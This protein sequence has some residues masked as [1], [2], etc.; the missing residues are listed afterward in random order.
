[1]V[2]ELIASLAS[3]RFDEN[4]RQW[5]ERL[6]RE[7]ADLRTLLPVLH[8]GGKVPMYF[9][10]VLGCVV[11]KAPEMMAPAL[12]ALF[13]LR[14]SLQ[15][16]GYRRSLAKWMYHAGL[17]QGM[18]G[19]AVDALFRWARDPAAQVSTRRFA[20][21]GLCRLVSAGP[22]SEAYGLREELRLV[23]EEQGELHTSNF[24]K[25]ASAMLA[26]LSPE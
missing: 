16:Q 10:W 8:A 11:E 17:P 6:I 23:L 20:L 21:L 18:E 2:E 3:D 25:Q 9:T 12:P 7:R 5:C 19:E 1:M 26:G 24:R 22:G 15:I 13:A 14:H 4:R